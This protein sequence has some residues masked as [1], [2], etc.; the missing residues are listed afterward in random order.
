MN[1]Q[2]IIVIGAS[3]GGVEALQ[4]LVRGLPSDLGAPV[5]VVIHMHPRS[6]SLMAEILTRSGPLIASQ[7]EHNAQI[8]SGRIYVAPPDHHLIIERN[9][10]CVSMGPKENYERPSIN[11]TFRSAALAY[12]AQVIGVV[13]TG[14][15]DDGAAGLWEI[16]RRGGV[17]VV[18]HPEE[19]VFPSM[20]L[21]ALREVEAD[22]TVR[23]AEM[24]PLL[25]HLSRQNRIKYEVSQGHPDVQPKVVD[26][27]CPECRGTIWEVSQ[28]RTTAYRCR[29]GHSFSPRTM[30]AEHS[31]AQEKAL[32]AAIVALEE[33]AVLVNKLAAG[34]EPD[35]Q[36]ELAEESR[37]KQE[38][39]HAIRRM[40]EDRKSFS[41]D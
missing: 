28:G 27:T 1:S 17:A 10:M 31:A 4:E 12:G 14:Q 23:L 19:A 36:A 38:Q 30:L 35:L 40:L 39:A 41:L 32:W 8:E 37:Q 22:H 3:A 24:G 11:V 15:L 13:L 29:V 2:K 9:R 5:F 18:Q 26:L 20:P 25:G 7:A 21:S 34:A 6:K 16:K 33:G